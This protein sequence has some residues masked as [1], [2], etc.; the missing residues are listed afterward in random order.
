[1]PGVL[2]LLQPRE[3]RDLPPPRAVAGCEVAASVR[4]SPL[5]GFCAGC[6]MKGALPASALRGV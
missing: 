2:G 5:A 1:L 6:A 4:A 3:G